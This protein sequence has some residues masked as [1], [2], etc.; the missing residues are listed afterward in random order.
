MFHEYHCIPRS[1]RAM[2][3]K[4]KAQDSEVQVKSLE[5]SEVEEY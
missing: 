2:F 5:G 1:W 4:L 3:K